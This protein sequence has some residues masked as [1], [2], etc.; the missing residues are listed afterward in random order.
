[1]DEEKEL[2]DMTDEEFE[3]WFWEHMPTDDSI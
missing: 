2:A 1:M 3:D